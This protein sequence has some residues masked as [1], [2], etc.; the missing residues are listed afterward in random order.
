MNNEQV[1]FTWRLVEILLV[2]VFTGLFLRSKTTLKTSEFFKGAAKSSMN[3]V[4]GSFRR[5]KSDASLQ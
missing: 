5:L 3:F 1:T 4:E 2:A